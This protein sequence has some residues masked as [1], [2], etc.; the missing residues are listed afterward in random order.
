[1]KSSI[2]R[3][4]RDLADEVDEIDLATERVVVDRGFVRYAKSVHVGY[5]MREW[6]GKE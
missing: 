3:Y 4:G 6:G 1:M 5:L 2:Q